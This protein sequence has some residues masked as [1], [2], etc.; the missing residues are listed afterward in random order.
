MVQNYQVVDGGLWANNPSL[1]AAIEAHFR[2]DVSLKD[3]RVLSVGTGTSK[4]FYPQST[5][6]WRERLIRSWQGWGVAT[7]WERNKLLDLILNL[8]SATAH[9]MLCLLLRESP[10]DPEHVLRLTF[11][12]DL[13]LPMDSTHKRG[14]W[15]AKSDLVFSHYSTKIA[16]FLAIQGAAR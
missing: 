13:P 16:R 7:R 4:S 12:S 10:L 1:V 8:Q 15:V 5:G 3:I 9:N 11:E 14:D 2:F 6:K